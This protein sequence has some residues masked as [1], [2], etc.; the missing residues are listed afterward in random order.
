MATSTAQNAYQLLM[1]AMQ[2][3]QN[4]DLDDL[5]RDIPGQPLVAQLSRNQS[6]PLVPNPAQGAGR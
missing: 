4:S 5:G 6:Q 2:R 1:Q 3:Y